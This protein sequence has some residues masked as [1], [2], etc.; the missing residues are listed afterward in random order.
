MK[1]TLVFTALFAF[2]C[3][4][5]HCGAEAYDQNPLVVSLEIPAPMD[6]AG[7]ILVADVND[8]GRQDYLVTV[9]GHLAVYDNSGRKLWIRQADLVVGSSSETHG[10]P[11]HHGSGV[12][13]GDVDADG[14]CE[15]VY[16][17]MD[18]V[19]HVLDGAGGEEEATARPP[20]PQ[21]A[22]R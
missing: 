16:L 9:P 15:V 7:G 2:G 11:G 3:L 6:S 19:V 21:G 4:P 5:I 14:R 10:L 20:V 1:C 17:T 8:D 12:A 13:A 22:A 18:G